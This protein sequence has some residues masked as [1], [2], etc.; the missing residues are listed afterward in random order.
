MQICE[1]CLRR[2]FFGGYGGLFLLIYTEQNT[3]YTTTHQ[4]P[5]I[6]VRERSLPS[7]RL[8]MTFPNDLLYLADRRMIKPQAFHHCPCS[9]GYLVTIPVFCVTK[10][11]SVQQAKQ[12]CSFMPGKHNGSSLAEKMHFIFHFV[13]F[14]Q[15]KLSLCELSHSFSRGFQPLCMLVSAPA[16]PSVFL[17]QLF[18]MSL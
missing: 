3:Y 13:F 17:T 7:S 5:D 1:K 10:K 4:G 16:P 11:G 18:I 8:C 6:P 14:S 12:Q 2:H 9:R 15:Y